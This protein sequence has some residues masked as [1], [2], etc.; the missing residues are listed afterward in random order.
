MNVFGAI[1]RL[2]LFKKQPQ[3]YFYIK[4]VQSVKTM[5]IILGTFKIRTK[6]DV[7]SYLSTY[8][9]NSAIET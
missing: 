7:M 2:E 3:F 6:I 9:I 5:F 8:L 1:N 4:K